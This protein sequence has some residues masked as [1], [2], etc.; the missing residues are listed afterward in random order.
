LTL[1]NM[2]N[3]IFGALALGGGEILIILGV[4]IFL[5][6]GG[7]ATGMGVLLLVCAKRKKTAVPNSPAVPPAN[8]TGTV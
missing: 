1:I 3:P 4:L 7:V 5:A 6:A 8:I 2:A